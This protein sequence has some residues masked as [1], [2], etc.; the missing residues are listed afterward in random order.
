MC[1]LSAHL[2]PWSL[3]M[4]GEAVSSHLGSAVERASLLVPTASVSVSPCAPVA[5]LWTS[6]FRQARDLRVGMCGTYMR[7]SLNSESGV[8]CLCKTMCLKGGAWIWNRALYVL[9]AGSLVGFQ[10]WSSKKYLHCEYKI[11]NYCP[12][13]FQKQFGKEPCPPKSC[14]GIRLVLLF[15]VMQR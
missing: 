14:L 9:R 7:C 2:V 15:L 10:A 13:L 12:Q 4:R 3:P 5:E 8:R 1:K 6:D 11:M